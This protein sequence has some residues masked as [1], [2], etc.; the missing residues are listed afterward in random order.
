MRSRP[1]VLGSLA[2]LVTISNAACSS[3]KEKSASELAVEANAQVL[4]ER[5]FSCCTPVELDALPFVDETD[6]PTEEGCVAYH[7]KTGLSYLAVTEGAANAGR[8]GL[9]VDA[10]EACV[11]TIR[12][13]TCSEFHSRLPRLH[14][15]DA[16]SL[17]NTAIVEPGVDDGGAC[18]LYIDCKGGFCAT[19]SGDAADGSENAEGTCKALPTA[20]QRC[21]AGACAEGFHCDAD[22]A[23]CQPY[24]ELGKACLDDNAC[25][26]G[27]C[28]GGKCVSPGLCGG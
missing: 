13:E 26:T 7:T 5:L 12:A 16:Y 24:I 15:G 1:L 10:S 2:L 14:L 17:C 19:A 11:E 18:T 20:G 21:L 22:T 25:A 6:P 4:C 27:A 28:R 3:D 9:H 23:V 8:A